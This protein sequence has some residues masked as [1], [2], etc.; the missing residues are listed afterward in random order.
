MWFS[1]RI[2]K[3]P[4]KV[5]IQKGSMDDDL[6]NGLWN[7]FCLFYIRPLGEQLLRMRSSSIGDARDFHDFF[8]ILWHN[9]LTT[10]SIM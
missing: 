5:E 10:Q 1:Q 9:F 4:V 3:K 8:M 6:R 7:A 2:G